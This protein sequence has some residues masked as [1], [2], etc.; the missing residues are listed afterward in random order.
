MYKN[1]IRLPE[2]IKIPFLLLRKSKLNADKY[3]RIEIWPNREWR[4]LKP[5]I[6]LFSFNI[7]MYGIWYRPASGLYSLSNIIN[8]NTKIVEINKNNNSFFF[9]YNLKIKKI[10]IINIKK[11]ELT[12]MSNGRKKLIN[13]AAKDEPMTPIIT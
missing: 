6:I 1:I 7:C 3:C 13:K 8:I 9:K 12:Q 10:I 11:I 5:I 4:L 2:G